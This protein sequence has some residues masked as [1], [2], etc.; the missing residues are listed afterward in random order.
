MKLKPRH[1]KIG[2]LTDALNAVPRH[3]LLMSNANIGRSIHANGIDIHFV[4][5]GAGEPLILLENGMI[6]TN[7]I[8]AEW[9]SSYGRHIDTLAKPFL[10]IAPVFRGSSRTVLPVVPISY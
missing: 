4:E 10:V 6:S 5:A 7:P 8:W 2:E 3:R 1:R 9:A